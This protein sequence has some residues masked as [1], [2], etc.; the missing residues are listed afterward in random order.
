MLTICYIAAG[1]II[2]MS[3]TVLVS[4]VGLAISIYSIVEAYKKDEQDFLAWIC[5]F[6]FMFFITTSLY[7]ETQDDSQQTSAQHPQVG[8]R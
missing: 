5:A 6:I 8:G 3:L 7:M 4:L 2:G 1:A